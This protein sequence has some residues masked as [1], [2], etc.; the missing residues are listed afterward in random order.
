MGTAPDQSMAG[1]EELRIA[2]DKVAVRGAN[3]GQ[4]SLARTSVKLLADE[5][6]RLAGAEQPSMGQA[7][8]NVYTD[9][10]ITALYLARRLN[11][12]DDLTNLPPEKSSGRFRY[13]IPG[14]VLQVRADAVPLLRK[15]LQEKGLGKIE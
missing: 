11:L 6:L 7:L 13:D 2:F 1:M 3:N 12:L 10:D 4:F 5:L 14:I 8:A 9:D 15:V